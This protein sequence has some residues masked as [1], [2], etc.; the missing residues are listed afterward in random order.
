MVLFLSPTIKPWPPAAS[1]QELF[2]HTL[3][4]KDTYSWLFRGANLVGSSYVC[5]SKKFTSELV[6]A[7]L[8][9][10]LSVIIVF[11]GLLAVWSFV[12]SLM[13]SVYS[14]SKRPCNF[15]NDSY[16]DKSI[17]MVLLESNMNKILDFW[18]LAAVESC[19]FGL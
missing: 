15:S 5:W 13:R 8:T 1:I 19:S 11:G 4:S 18:T 6:A 7:L 14:S 2:K 12:F 17:I 10:L 16:I 9:K 3:W